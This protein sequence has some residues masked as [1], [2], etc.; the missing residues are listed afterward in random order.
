MI[1]TIILYAIF[2]MFHPHPLPLCKDVNY[3]T[4]TGHCDMNGAGAYRVWKWT[5]DS[6]KME[7]GECGD[8]LWGEFICSTVEMC[9][10]GDASKWSDETIFDGH[11]WVKRDR[12]IIESEKKYCS[13]HVKG[14]VMWEW[15][16]VPAEGEK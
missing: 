13:E 11:D 3:K 6:A 10:E 9:R 2:R 16:F 4:F 5:V 12:N 7:P 15:E 8:R 1:P 14:T